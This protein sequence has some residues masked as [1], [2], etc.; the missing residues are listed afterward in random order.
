MTAAAPGGFQIR[1]WRPHQKETLVAFFSIVLP[2]GLIIRDCRLHKKGDRRWIG[3]PTKT[4]ES[5][6]ER[7]FTPTVDFLDREVENNFQRLALEAIDRH[8]SE[9]KE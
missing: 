1:D 8:L 2:S 7:K 4:F 9:A 3:M 5:Q 6:G